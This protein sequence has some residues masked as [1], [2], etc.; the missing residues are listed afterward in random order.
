MRVEMLRSWLGCP[1]TKRSRSNFLEPL[2]ASH[3]ENVETAFDLVRAHAGLNA[4]NENI[5]SQRPTNTPP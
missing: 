2:V 1:K 5:V 3:P 4:V